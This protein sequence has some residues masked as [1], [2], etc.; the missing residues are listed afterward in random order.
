MYL[1]NKDS[2]V[3]IM[4]IGLIVFCQLIRKIFKFIIAV[5]KFPFKAI[6]W[7]YRF[8]LRMFKDNV[9]SIIRRI[10]DRMVM[11]SE[12]FCDLYLRSL[13]CHAEVINPI[14]EAGIKRLAADAGLNPIETKVTRATIKYILQERGFGPI[15]DALPSYMEPYY[16]LLVNSGLVSEED[17][18]SVFGEVKMEQLFSSG[19]D[20]P[21]T[22]E[23]F[24][25]KVVGRYT[26]ENYKPIKIVDTE[27]EPGSGIVDDKLLVMMLGVDRVFSLD[28][29]YRVFCNHNLKGVKDD[30][31]QTT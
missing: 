25:I 11:T 20:R 21:L 12:P 23:D 2:F 27:S 14:T 9:T 1:S 18:P 22:H 5:I 15:E 8:V 6:V 24:S 4:I 7:I 30:T 10:V 26:G 17:V 29:D 28:N 13:D 19:P 3:C 16:H 31:Y